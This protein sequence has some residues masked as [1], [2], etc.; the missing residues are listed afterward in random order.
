VGLADGAGGVLGVGEGPDVLVAEA[1]VAVCRT[2]PYRRFVPETQF[3][4][5]IVAG[6]VFGIAV[7]LQP[8][9]SFYFESSLY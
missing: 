6:D 5:D 7:Y 1:A 2:V 3:V 4:R 8:G 9:E